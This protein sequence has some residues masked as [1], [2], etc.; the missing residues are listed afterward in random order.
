MYHPIKMANALTPTKWF[1]S[2]NLHTPER[3]N[4]DDHPPRLKISFLIDSGASFAVLNYPTYLTIAKRLNLTCDN[5][6][7]HT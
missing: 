3:Y 4:N 1:Y 6:T 5:K 7:N 2:L